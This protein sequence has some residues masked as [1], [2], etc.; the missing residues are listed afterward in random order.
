M[1]TPSMLAQSRS[2]LSDLAESVYDHVAQ[3]RISDPRD[4]FPKDPPKPTADGEAW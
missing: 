1:T 2:T 3:Q 4:P